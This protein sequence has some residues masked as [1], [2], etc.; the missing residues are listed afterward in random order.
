MPPSAGVSLISSAR[1]VSPAGQ[2]QAKRSLG[3]HLLHGLWGCSCPCSPRLRAAADP[4]AAGSRSPAT[5]GDCEQAGGYGGYNQGG[6]RGGRML[7]EKNTVCCAR[8]LRQRRGGWVKEGGSGQEGVS[9]GFQGTCWAV[10]ELELLLQNKLFDRDPSWPSVLPFSL[11]VYLV[12]LL[13]GAWLPTGCC[14]SE[15][16]WKMGISCPPLP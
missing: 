8:R 12:V 13:L 1:R 4:P 14:C 10:S 2:K 7:A 9:D 16:F 6:V 3:K 11:A 15:G 5:G